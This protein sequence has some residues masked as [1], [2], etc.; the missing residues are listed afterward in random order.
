MI[1]L[2]VCNCFALSIHAPPCENERMSI[3]WRSVRIQKDN[4]KPRSG[5]YSPWSKSRKAITISHHHLLSPSPISI[6]SH[7]HL[8]LSAS[9]IS[10][11]HHHLA[12]SSPISI[13][14]QHLPPSL[15]S[16]TISYHHLC[17]DFP[18]YKVDMAVS[19][20]TH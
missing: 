14:H 15:S 8:L 17:D 11:S 1:L 7:H 12:S 19:A 6:Y 20:M 5:T 10:I 4:M 2:R 3:K 9:P 16:I 18:Q 13:S